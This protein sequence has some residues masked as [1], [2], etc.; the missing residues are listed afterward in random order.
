MLTG[1]PLFQADSEFGLVE[2]VVSQEQASPA[3][4]QRGVSRDLETICLKC[5]Q[6]EPGKR[7]TSAQDLAEDLRRFLR[8]EPFRA[9]R[10][11]MWGRGIKWA[12]R[13]PTL[14]ALAATAA[15]QPQGHCRELGYIFQ[16]MREVLPIAS[17][18][19][20]V[21]LLL[22]TGFMIV[23][24]VLSTSI[25]VLFGH[26]INS[27]A[28]TLAAG[29]SGWPVVRLAIFFL[30]LI[31]GVYLARELLT[32]YQKYLIQSVCT[33]IQRDMTVVVVS[34]LFK[35]DLAT[36]ARERLGSLHGRIARSVDGFIYLLVMIFT[37][38]LP[39]LIAIVCALAW[40]FSVDYRVRV[41]IVGVIPLFMALT[42]RQIGSQTSTLRKMLRS[43]VTLDGTVLERLGGLEYIRAAHT[44]RQ[45]VD[46]V[47]QV[48]EEQRVQKMRYQLAV[49]GYECLKALNEGFFHL[50]VLGLGIY[51]AFRQ[52]IQPGDIVS[53]SLLFYQVVSPL[54][55]MG[56][57]LENAQDCSLSSSKISPRAAYNASSY[58]TSL[59]V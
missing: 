46:R 11:G 12:R 1:R 51:L 24:S 54:K 55:S 16:Q 22:A 9:R 36:L 7:Y 31:A 10:T 53:F 39:G 48:A 44:Y 30:G 35:A 3:R 27:L 29:P 37:E 2:Q 47:E 57:L 38:F 40:V 49:A 34:H 6:K 17:R 13:R 15:E 42:L 28:E 4:L 26:L 43:R 8:D 56:I 23:N 5:L 52:E 41:V 45:E 18:R 32:L 50:L 58:W 25:P 20:K 19:H 14:A 59:S 21:M 33:R